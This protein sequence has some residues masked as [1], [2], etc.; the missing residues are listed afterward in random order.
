MYVECPD[1]GADLAR[2]TTNPDTEEGLELCFTL[3]YYSRLR[4]VSNLLPLLHQSLHPRVLSIL[5]GTKEKRVNRNDLGL[6]KNWAILAVVNHTTICTSLAFD[7]LAANDSKKH[8]TFIHATPGFVNTGTPRTTY[9]T[10]KDGML[11]WAF[12][13]VMQ[14]VSG[15]IIRYFGMSLSESGERNAFYLTSDKFMPGSWQTNRYNDIISPNSALKYYQEGGYAQKVWDHTE[16][17]WDR[18]LTNS[19]LS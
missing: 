8:I 15:W 17:V 9:P 16:R 7:Y 19:A 14:V 6:E 11:R 13:C 3:S 5:N 4:L 12:L 1:P 18:A 2:L 10:R